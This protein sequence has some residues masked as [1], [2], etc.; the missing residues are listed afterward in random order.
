MKDV[1]LVLLAGVLGALGCTSTPKRDLRQPTA[2][3][4][5]TLPPNAY[6]QPFTPPRQEQLLTPKATAPNLNSMGGPMSGPGMGG[7]GG[8]PMMGAPGGARR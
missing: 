2:E 8:G 3:E 6:N 1:R 7:P 4:F 5:P